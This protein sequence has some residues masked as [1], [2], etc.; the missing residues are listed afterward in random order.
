[1]TNELNDVIKQKALLRDALLARYGEL[2]SELP[3]EMVNVLL[4]RFTVNGAIPVTLDD[5]KAL[6]SQAVSQMR[7]ELRDALPD[8]GRPSASASAPHEAC[9][10]PRFQWWT[11]GG[12]WHMVPEGWRFPSTDA[13]TTWNLWHFGHVADRIQPLRKLRAA[14]SPVHRR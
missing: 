7:T 5:I 6:M 9:D 14:D 3:T 8:P 2:R 11:W 4:S 12:S 13:K 10:D 1:M